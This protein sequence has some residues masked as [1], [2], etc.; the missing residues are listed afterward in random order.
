M[1]NPDPKSIKLGAPFLGYHEDGSQ[2]SGVI[3]NLIDE[4]GDDTEAAEDAAVIIVR[5]NDDCWWTVSLSEIER[6]IEQ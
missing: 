3:T 1:I 6:I 5:V 4:Y 2:L